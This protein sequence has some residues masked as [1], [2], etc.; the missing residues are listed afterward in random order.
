MTY[1]AKL[2]DTW[3]MIS[4][5]KYGDEKYVI[6]L[7]VGNPVYRDVVVFEGGEVLDIPA[8]E[9]SLSSDLPPWRR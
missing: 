7:M 3:D 8:I 5:R 9:V 2:G 4:L 6:P 1:T